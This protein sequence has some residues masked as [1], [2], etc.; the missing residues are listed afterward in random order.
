M[1]ILIVKLNKCHIDDILLIEK[2][3]FSEPKSAITVEEELNNK[4]YTFFGY[5]INKKIV[6]YLNYSKILD[7]INIGNIGVLKS[8]RK[9]GIGTELLKFLISENK[10]CN[11]F[12]EV[13]ESNLPAIILYKN[14]GFKQISIRK[15]YYKNPTENALI[16]KR[17]KTI[18]ENFSN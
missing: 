17:N 8:H 15:N 16:L 5:Q 18:Y 4:I 10:N 7:E 11:I 1:I 2:E 3:C 6:A 13:R 9:C 12:L 14:Q